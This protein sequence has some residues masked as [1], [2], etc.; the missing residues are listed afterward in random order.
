MHTG[1]ISKQ[2]ADPEALAIAESWGW[3]S[4]PAEVLTVAMQAV[5]ATRYKSADFMVRLG[6]MS[7][8]KAKALLAAKPE[9]MQTIAWFAQQ[10]TE[11]FPS[12]R[13]L[14][15]KSMVPYYEVMSVLSVHPCMD[16]VLVRSRAEELDA[17]VMQIE[18]EAPCIV[19]A[20]FAGLLKYRSMGRGE[21]MTD[22]ILLALSGGEPHMAVGGRDEIS[23]VL[24]GFAEEHGMGAMES[25]NVWSAESAE[26]R[27]SA[28]NREI[29]RLLDHAIKIGATDISLRP[30]RTGE[31]HV[32]M[33]RFGKM[34]VPKVV[35]DRM[36]AAL[37]AEVVNVLQAKSG[38]NPTNS[39]L[40]VPSDG[41]VTY[42][43]SVGDAFL[44]FSFVPL[45]HLGEKRN[46]TS[47]SC[48]I[49][50]RSESSVMLG[51]LRLAPALIQEI[52][53]AMQISQG[54]VLVVGPTNSGKSTTIAGAIGEHVKLFGDAMKRVSVEDPIERFLY[55]IMQINALPLRLAKT[56]EER[57]AIILRSIKRHDPDM[58][59]IG[60]VRDKVTAD[61]CVGS[62]ITGHLVLSS[63]HANDTLMGFDAL[64]RTVEPDKRFQLVESMS[65]VISQRLIKELCPHCRVIEAASDDDHRIFTRY[66]QIVDDEGDLPSTVARANPKGCRHC[67]H[68]GYVGLLPINEV[69]PFT[70][71]VKNAAH[72]LINGANTR[73]EIAAA[74]TVKLLDSSLALVAD[75]RIAFGDLLV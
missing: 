66:L 9:G 51:D 74:R 65:I 53:F 58:I 26:N 34:V 48:R 28:V 8:A 75:H 32:Q 44:R 25:S 31:M 64:A 19:F 45:N 72:A 39:T 24:K 15:L 40:R 7:D 12:E 22:A 43:S 57:F 56:E 21:R 61:L 30:F 18:G 10:I 13:I 69:L 70:R 42:L 5:D 2:A 33:R 16:D 3:T 37:A 1:R 50:P 20:S 41:Q 68:D 49:L 46:L 6:I 4:P 71:S 73:D 38:A 63:L 36:S 55:G 17:V 23:A 47:V 60:E 54:L 11:A 62:A 27:A 52:Q 14:A 35:N 67:G 59:W 29:T